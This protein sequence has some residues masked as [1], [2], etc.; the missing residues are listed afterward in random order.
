MVCLSEPVAPVE[1]SETRFAFGKNWASF[2]DRFDTE[3]LQH[4]T[5]SLKTLLQA[6]SL[7]GKRFLDIGSG[8]GLFS[9]AA[10]SMGAEVVSVDLDDDSVACTRALRE[11]AVAENPTVAEQ[12]Q[13]HQGSAL[14]AEW[15]TSL[16]TFD[17]V[18]SWG[19]LHHTGQMN[20][21][22]E[23]TSSVVAPGGQYAIA[24]YNDQG[25]GSRR[26]LQIKQGYHR[27][28]AFLRPAYV[29]LVAGCYEL[30]F[31]LARLARGR[32]PLPFADWRA[33]KSDR[34]M[35]AWHDWVD[36]IG[37]LPFEVAKPEAIILPLRE[38][39]FVLD[40]LTTV[41]SGWGCNEYVFCRC[42]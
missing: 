41:G 7:A 1:E 33:K 32:N 5:S 30:K 37:G 23:A 2:L 15:L 20:V 38:K 21:A 35:N 25:G 36:W 26:W 8:S 39:G 6:E 40:N 10:V 12:W 18:Y 9:L 13:V 14:D 28:P 4:A 3:R 29:V 31:A 22:I 11:R 42:K 34:G 27:L 19:V 17:V 24:I 16:G